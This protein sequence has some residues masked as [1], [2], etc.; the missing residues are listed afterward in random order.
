MDRRD[1]LSATAKTT[2]G[3]AAFMA[4]NPRSS[5]A[6]AAN[7][8]IVFAQ[9]GL[10]GRGKSVGREFARLDGVEMKYACD[11]DLSRAGG[12]ID[13]VKA[14]QGK[15]PRVLQDFRNAL[16]DKDVD[17]VIVSTPD[18]WHALAAIWACQAGKDVYVEKPP[19]HNIWEGRKMVEAARKYNRI[20]QTGTQ[21]RSAPYVNEAKQYID[22]GNI[23]KLVYVKVFGMEPGYSY[24]EPRNTPTPASVDYDMYLGAAPMR[25]FNRGHFHGNWHYYWAYSGGDLAD[26]GVHQMDI[27][28]WIMGKDYPKYISGYGNNNAFDDERDVFDTQS[29]IY[30]YGDLTM[31]WE[32]TQWAKYMRKTPT[33]VRDSDRFPQW[34]LNATRIEFYGTNGRLVL[35]R[36]GGGYQAIDHTGKIVAG[37]YGRMADPE[38]RQNFADCI[39]SRKLPNA[40]IEEGHRS[41]VLAHA[42]NIATRLQGH[43]L[44]FDSKSESFIENPKANAL[45]KRKYR[46]PYEVPEHV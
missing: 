28:R 39:R 6:Y 40:D 14:A 46:T 9:I 38:H 30:D 29:V 45:V 15:E 43:R 22:E 31:T 5:R 24:I 32:L 42:G 16:D 8:K 25:P 12:V 1:F 4:A 13:Q 2:L 26:D 20:V 23:G 33:E 7:D 35:G 37:A 19:S 21:N 17:A 10:G 44:E 18:H 36:H 27:A 3:A 41:A 11:V 34:D